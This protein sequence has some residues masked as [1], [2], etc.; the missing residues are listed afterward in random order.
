MLKVL[1]RRM[2][3]VAQARELE[4]TLAENAYAL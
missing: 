3:A 1:D 4:D 2:A